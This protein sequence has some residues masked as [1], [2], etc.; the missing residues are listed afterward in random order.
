MNGNLGASSS[1]SP[2]PVEARN[3]NQPPSPS[4]AFVYLLRWGG[5][6][7]GDAGRGRGTHWSFCFLP[8]EISGKILN[9]ADTLTSPPSSLWCACCKMFGLGDLFALH[10][11]ICADFIVLT[12][13]IFSAFLYSFIVRQSLSY[14]TCI[15][16]CKNYSPFHCDLIGLYYINT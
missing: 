15:V 10:G 9:S 14:I 2:S 5:S 7:W 16:F 8:L 12:G 4:Y 6:G 1:Q 3:A 13:R 11:C